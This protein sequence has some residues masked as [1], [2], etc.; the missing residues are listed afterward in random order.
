MN[1]NLLAWLLFTGLDEKRAQI[2][3]A[4]LTHGEA[5]AQEL[6]SDLKMGRTAIYDNLRVLEERGYI[7]PV[8]SGKRKVFLPIHP[9]ELFKKFENQKQQLKDLLPDFLAIYA[10][11]NKKPFVQVYSGPFS[12]R[13]VY[14]DILA[15]TKR[16]YVYLS[17]PQLTLKTVDRK[18]MEKWVKRRVEKGLKSRSLR[19]KSKSSDIPNV[20]QDEKKYL[21]QIRYLPGY[22][23]LKSSIYIYGN[24]IGI[25][26]TSKENA[27]FIVFSPDLA[28]SLKQIFEFLWGVSLRTAE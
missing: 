3:L 13:E 14:E 24:N 5:T 10:A 8:L 18:W 25:I 15:A 12:A 4:A 6:A 7:T 16:E 23:D 9:K 19:V 11:E 26:S 21:R 2:Y 17:P 28:F 1:N 27:A 22:V 20:F